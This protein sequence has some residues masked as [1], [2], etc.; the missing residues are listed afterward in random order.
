MME[1]IVISDPNA[2]DNEAKLINSLFDAGLR[3]FH[4]RKPYWNNNQ[5]VELLSGV[6]P[7]YHRLIALHQHHYLAERFD[8]KRLHYPELQRFNTDVQMIRSQKKEGYIISTSV[9]DLNLLPALQHFDYV[10]FSPVFDSISKKNY[11][12]NLP[13]DFKLNKNKIKTDI[14]ALGGV[15]KSNLYTVKTM[16]FD[17]AAV[18]GTLWNEPHRAVERFKELKENLPN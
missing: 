14:I 4:L 3:R 6:T 1:L 12:S 2:I 16:G 11:L 9:H 13:R 5:F 10:F 17:G 15:D 7:D 18:L 8:I